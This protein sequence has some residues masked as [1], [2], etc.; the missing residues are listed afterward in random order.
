MDVSIALA[1]I[2][3]ASLVVTGILTPIAVAVVQYKIQS[4]ERAEDKLGRDK[5]AHA[6]TL[7]AEVQANRSAAVDE[8]L[9]DLRTLSESTHGLVNSRLSAILLSLHDALVGQI[10][11]LR[12]NVVVREKGGEPPSADALAAIDSLKRGLQTSAP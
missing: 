7:V 6:V 8:K 9:H 3:L 4:A 5:V 10:E 2:A 1:L 11:A 12:D